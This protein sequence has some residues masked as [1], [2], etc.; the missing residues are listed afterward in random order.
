MIKY[1]TVLEILSEQDRWTNNH[2]ARNKYGSPVNPESEDAIR[3]CIVGA[4]RKVYGAA[5]KECDEAIEKIQ[6]EIYKVSH[7]KI[8]RFND[9]RIYPEVL[10][11]LQ[12]AKI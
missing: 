10:K 2:L 11:I 1:K 7:S 12:A 9:T 3:W 4:C 6:A 5:S 8:P